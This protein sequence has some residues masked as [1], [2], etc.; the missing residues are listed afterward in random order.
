[1]RPADHIGQF[2]GAVHNGGVHGALGA[3]RVNAANKIVRIR[4]GVAFAQTPLNG[5]AG[6]QGDKADSHIFLLLQVVLRHLAY[7]NILYADL[8]QFVDQLFQ[9]TPLQAGEQAHLVPVWGMVQSLQRVVSGFFLDAFRD[10]PN[11]H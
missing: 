5:V 3:G 7:G 11:T 2:N 10:H 9:I 6:G 4:I 1:M 8:P